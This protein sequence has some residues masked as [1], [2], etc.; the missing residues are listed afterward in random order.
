MRE[1]VIYDPIEEEDEEDEE[2][3]DEEDEEDFDPLKLS[4]GSRS[5]IKRSRKRDSAVLFDIS[6]GDLED[7]DLAGFLTEK[8]SGKDWYCVL[9]DQ[10]LCL[11]PSQDANEL[12]YDVVILP[13]CQ[14][15]L[16]DR[17]MRTPVFRLTQPGM[18]PWVLVAKD[19][20]ELKEWISALTTAASG[21]KYSLTSSSSNSTKS[22]RAVSSGVSGMHAITEEE[23]AEEETNHEST[24]I[25]ITEIEK[26][27]VNHDTNNK[28]T[29]NRL[30]CIITE[31]IGKAMVKHG[32]KR[33]ENT[34]LFYV[35]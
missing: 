3:E 18:A 29:M 2:E 10:H 19:N 1:L 23:P 33:H 11:F 35:L 34:K 5:S 30:N 26:D 24:K 21:G 7:F 22:V 31:E 20:E 27:E 13:C 6:L 15:S 16:D 28:P 12:A 9:M 8:H 4:T 14:I 32:I 25:V 17:L